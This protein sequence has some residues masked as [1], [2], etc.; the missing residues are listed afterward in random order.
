MHFS[1]MHFSKILQI[2]GGLVLGCIKTKFCK[3][4][5]VWQHFSSSTRFA[6]FCTAAISKFCKKKLVWKTAIFVK[7]Q[8]K[9]VQMSQNLQN[10]A[11]FQKC[12]LDNLVDFEKCCKTHIFLQKSEPIQPKTSNTLPKFCQPTLSDVSASELL[13]ARAL[14][15]LARSHETQLV[16]DDYEKVTSKEA[17]EWW[18]GFPPKLRRAR[19]RLY[20]NEILQENMRSTAFFKL[21]KICILLHR[22]NLKIFAKNRFEKSAILVKIQQIFCKCRKICKKCQNFKNF[23]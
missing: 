5:C 8:Q 22:C 1:K 2:F 21:C 10:F 18:I 6:S 14:D 9:I 20:Q 23:S 11:T 19:S 3:K 15:D 4:T 7:F 17:N 12:Q 16:P 13:Q